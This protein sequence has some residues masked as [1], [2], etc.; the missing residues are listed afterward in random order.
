[1]CNTV[2]L[3]A[4]MSIGHRRF[5]Q[6][7]KHLLGNSFLIFQRIHFS[8]RAIYMSCTLPLSLL[9]AF[10]TAVRHRSADEA[11]LC[12]AATSH[13]VATFCALQHVLALRTP[14]PICFRRH[15]AQQTKVMHRRTAL[16]S[17]GLVVVV[18]CRAALW[19][20]PRIA[21]P[22]RRSHLEIDNRDSVYNEAR[23]EKLLL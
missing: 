3:S 1:L 6:Q 8:E 15:H 4:S 22:A 14:H 21:S 9:V 19:A 23:R 20:E 17:L 16:S 5:G 10:G 18:R 7:H 13:V 11:E 12:T 2:R